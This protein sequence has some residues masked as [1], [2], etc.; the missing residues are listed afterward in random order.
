[1]TILT[2]AAG[3]GA[4]VVGT[5]TGALSWLPWVLAAGSLALGAGGTLWYRSE[6]K[7]CQA[8][9]AIDAAKAAAQVAAAKDADAKFTRGLAEQLQPVLGAIQE[10][11]RATSTALAKVKSDPNCLR[12]P[13]AAA[14]DAG[15]LPKPGDQAPARKP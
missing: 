15:V 8:S 6:W 13:A 14:F 1:M 12:T 9:V 2:E 4:K 7:D 11:S 10:Q 5:V 3:A